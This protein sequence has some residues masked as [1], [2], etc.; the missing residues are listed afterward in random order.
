M[1]GEVR[2]TLLSWAHGPE[3]LRTAV[4]RQGETSMSPSRSGMWVWARVVP[5]TVFDLSP[6]EVRRLVVREEDRGATA[7]MADPARDM[8]WMVHLDS[9]GVSR[10]SAYD[11]RSA[12]Y[13][14]LRTV[15]PPFRPAVIRDG[16]VMGFKPVMGSIGLVAYD[17]HTERFARE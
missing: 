3:A 13:L 11:T 12:G 7:I 1:R 16:V 6:R 10:Y 2:D 4:A 5:D 17:L 8:L 14:G 9:T 15:E